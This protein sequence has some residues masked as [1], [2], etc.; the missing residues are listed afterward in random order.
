M[1][2]EKAIALVMMG[3]TVFA[4]LPMF[5][6]A[7][8]DIFV[9]YC[10]DESEILSWLA[11]G[12]HM[13]NLKVQAIDGEP[14]LPFEIAKILLP[15]YTSVADVFVQATFGGQQFVDDIPCGQPP[16]V[17]GEEPTIVEKD[18]SIY[19]SDDLYPGIFYDVGSVTSFRGYNILRVQLYPVQYRPV[20]KM[21]I[22][23]TEM[24]VQVK[25][26]ADDKMDT[27]RNL[28]K[29]REIAEN[30]VDNPWTLSTYDSIQGTMGTLGGTTYEYLIITTVPLLDEFQVLADWKADWVNGA[31]V[32]TVSA[33]TS[34][35]EIK[36]IINDYYTYY[37]TSYVLLGG[38]VGVIPYHTKQVMGTNIAEDYWFA[39]LVGDDDISEYEVYIGRAPVEND[40]EAAHF[41]NKVISFEQMNKPMANLFHQSRVLPGNN[42][43]SRELAWQCQQYVPPGYI[44]YELFEENGRI[45]KAD[46]IDFWRNDGILCEHIG[47]GSP[48]SYYINY[49]VGGGHVTWYNTDVASMDNTFWPVH[50]S[51]A[52]HTGEFTYNDC[53]A[54]DYVKGDHGAVACFMNDK[55]GWFSYSDATYLSGDFIEMQFHA[56]YQ[57]D[58]QSIGAILAHSKYHFID[59]ATDPSH[60]HRAYWEYCWREINLFGDPETPVLTKRPS[61]PATP[62]PPSG[63]TSGYV[64]T[65]YSYS[66][67][68][69]DPEGDDVLYEF[70][71][72]DGTTTTVGPYP[73]GETA[74]ASHQW[75]RPVTYQVKV[76]AKDIY[77]A[78]SGWSSPMEVGLGQ[79]DANSG[80]DAGNNF[81]AATSISSG[82]TYKG[83]LY[84]ANPLDTQDWYKFYAANGKYIKAYVWP[85][86]GVDF[87][88][89]LF[90]ANG[91]LRASSKNGP[92]EQ[93]YIYYQSDVSGYWRI[94]VYI[95]DGEGQYSFKVI[96]YSS[97]GGCPI[98]YVYD[99]QEYAHEGLLDIHDPEGT[100]I[101]TDHTLISTPKREMGTYQLR[102][103][104]HPQTS[105]HID[106][107]KFYA[108]LKDKTLVELPLMWAWHSEDGYVR[109]QL[110]FSDD[111]KT[112]LLGENH[113]NGTSQSIYL[114]FIAPPSNKEVI[115]FLFVIEGNNKEIKPPPDI[116]AEPQQ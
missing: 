57:E 100:D 83:T 8:D 109:R 18:S 95:Y 4:T 103:T 28:F 115:G 33:G 82:V 53:L 76:R 80:G 12:E 54:E 17:I 113:N 40:A 64:Y 69:T 35:E 56:L 6:V 85:P 52:C 71:W 62:S 107:I 51:V 77:G 93:E 29:D 48:M 50:T 32:E 92:G 47:H 97:G 16:C 31:R 116:P 24:T 42:P 30:L 108:I 21:A 23:Y 36:N 104:E 67:S 65:S 99:G 86:S 105:S 55:N 14:L 10:F 15:P 87:D 98:L 84:E 94:H 89:Q 112:D 22:Y 68:T 41:V 110:L 25:L 63:P 20:S 111:W 74:S 46:W 88:L 73:S 27:F 59:E 1:R 44:H 91:N 101:I 61:P 26:V 2:K 39:N 7:T 66:T 38:D 58:Y 43:D 13:K 45:E 11:N 114:R 49:E 79:N 96:V 3:I 70:S 81:S 5:A 9:T 72:G 34:A 75:A 90:D 102:L 78:W 106:Q 37:G 60:P 19:D